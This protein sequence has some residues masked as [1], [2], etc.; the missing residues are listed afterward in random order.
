MTPELMELGSAI[1]LVIG[2]TVV[3]GCFGC[4]IYNII[5]LIIENSELA[6][7]VDNIKE[8]IVKMYEREER[9]NK[10]RKK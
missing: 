10:R 8:V 5:L 2:S 3:A 6:K 7:D 9:K 4:I 1:G